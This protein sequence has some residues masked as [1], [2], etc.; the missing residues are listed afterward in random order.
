MFP[1]GQPSGNPVHKSPGVMQFCSFLCLTEKLLFPVHHWTLTVSA[2]YMP[3][4]SNTWADAVSQ[5]ITSVEWSLHQGIINFLTQR[6]RILIA[7]LLVS[8][9]NHELPLYLS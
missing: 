7:N 3:E 6:W 9:T 8:H 1:D 5:G 2:T 4:V